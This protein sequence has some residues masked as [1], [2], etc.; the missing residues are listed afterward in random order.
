VSCGLRD[1][2]SFESADRPAVLVASS[3]FEGAAAHQAA[4][5]GQPE[6]RRVLVPHPIQDRTDDELRE[7]ARSAVDEILGCLRD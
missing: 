4:A 5:L 2:L 7:L 1:V 6:I 3:A